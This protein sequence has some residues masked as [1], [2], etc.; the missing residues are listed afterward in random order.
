MKI[1]FLGTGTSTGVP[2][3]GCQCEVCTSQ[4][5]KDRRL[6]ASV[7]INIES[8]NILIDCGPDFRQQILSEPFRRIHG[9][10]V[11]HE[12][13]DHMSGLDD[14]RPFAKLGD[15]EIYS[16]EITLNA[17]K[18]RMPYSFAEHRYPG[19]PALNLHEINADEV[20]CIEEVEIQPV[21]IM[22]Y[23]L[24]ILGYRIGDFAYLTDVKVIPEEEFEKLKG[25]D[26]LVINAL[27]TGEHIAHLSLSEALKLIERIAPQKAYLTHMSH[28]IGLHEEVQKTLP[29][30]VFLAYDGL[31]LE[32]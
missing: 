14:L 1:K 9:V 29:D 13:Y 15:L 31:E 27:R 12:H 2:E 30:N 23:R 18:K 22:H 6:R 21:N 11:T 16:N 19:V 3:I 5:I 28:Q 8:T 20:F 25:L 4:D 26:T 7:L 10:L 17:L 32:V 24:P